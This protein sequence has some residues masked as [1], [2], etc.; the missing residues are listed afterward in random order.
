MSFWSSFSESKKTQAFLEPV[1]PLRN[2]SIKRLVII[3]IYRP[4]AKEKIDKMQHVQT[5]AIE[6]IED[7]GR[8][9][10]ESFTAMRSMPM[11][12]AVTSPAMA[13]LL[14]LYV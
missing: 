2:I 8:P 13:K 14:F 3:S 12:V 5:P 4:P 9:S 11:A 10:A 7:G 1:I 6:L